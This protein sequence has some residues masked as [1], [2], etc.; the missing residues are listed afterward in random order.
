M[1]QL[2]PT[3]KQHL[4]AKIEEGQELREQYLNT[5]ENSEETSAVTR[6]MSGYLWKYG[7]LAFILCLLA[8]NLFI[9]LKFRQFGYDQY[10]GSLIGWMLLFNHLACY[11]T[12]KGWKSLVMKTVAGVWIMLVFVY[13]FSL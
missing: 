4:D 2:T 1:R 12:T 11:F 5:P 9:F 10:G 13:F 6:F 7:M 3:E 8:Y